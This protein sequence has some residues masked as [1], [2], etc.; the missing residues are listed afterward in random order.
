MTQR[1]PADIA[2][3]DADLQRQVLDFLDGSNFG[4]AQGG[5]RIDTHASMVFLGTDRALK[6]KRA[7]RLPFLDYSTLEK[8]KRACEEEL[9]VNAGNA[10][11]LY[12]R[13]VAITREP[14]GAFA[15]DGAGTAVE[16][17]VEMTRFDET[18]SLDQVA[19]SKTIEP[20]LA[21]ALA[22]AILRSHANAPRRN[23]E[24]WLSSILPIIERNTAKFRAARGLDTGAVDQLDAASR[25]WVTRLQPLLRQRAE[26]GYV[27]RCHGDLH[28][29][30]VALVGGRPL[31]FDA[32]EF[33]PVIA[34]TDVLYDLAFTLM[35]LIHFEQAA[36]ANTVYNRYLAGAGKEGLDGL[37]LLPLFLSIRAAIR[38]HVLFVKS[39]SATDGESARQQAKRYFDLAGRL[40]KPNP[41]LLVAIGG[42]SGTGKSVLAR[43]L[44][45]LVEP[46]PGALIVR[47]DVV[48]KH[49]FGT[50]ESVALPESAYRPDTSK[51][52]YDELLDTARHVLVQ[53]CSV[54]VDAVYME[55]AERTEIADLAAKQGV[56]FLGLFL[57]ADL[58]TRL[59]RIEQRKD[60]ASDATRNVALKQEAAAIGAVNWHRI[61][62]SGTP[63]QTL[64]GARIFLPAQPG[65][66]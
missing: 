24:S 36:A 35:D 6:I 39:E 15:I 66:R 12:R 7:V 59:A 22:D 5:K 45:S 65:E 63:D 32:I 64:A 31:L 54:V 14:D 43:Q 41:P 20:S 3:S 44:A 29:A 19:S 23:G 49:L 57:T 56:G 13:V 53:G 50:N 38:A 9:K 8:R 33:D 25:D 10:P 11:E 42:L 40:V 26:Q 18:Q 37:H 51:R 4:P 52:V 58:E 48:R 21:A 61:N 47:S 1:P 16:W 27:R 30:N 62:A 55:E 34:T 2:V 60:D 46:L 28:L 17:A